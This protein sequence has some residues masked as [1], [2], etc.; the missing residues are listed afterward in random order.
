MYGMIFVATLL[1]VGVGILETSS[2]VAPDWMKKAVESRL[3]HAIGTESI[4]VNE[5]RLGFDLMKLRPE[6]QLQSAEIG[7]T[8]SLESVKVYNLA[9]TVELLPLL[10]NELETHEMSIQEVQARFLY[11]AS[12][13]EPDL[14]EETESATVET[15]GSSE[16]A[17]APVQDPPEMR[18]RLDRLLA[19][20]IEQLAVNSF[21]LEAVDRGTGNHWLVS[22]DDF[23]MAG[24]PGG[25]SGNVSI[26]L[27]RNGQPDPLEFSA[28]AVARQEL[29]GTTVR[30]DISG[31]E[32]ANLSGL[33]SNS[34]VTGTGGESIAASFTLL[35]DEIGKL[36]GAEGST[37]ISQFSLSI[38]GSETPV[39]VQELG[40]FLT[41]DA[42]EN[43]I[44]IQDMLF[45][46]G[47]ASG[48]ASGHAYFVNS[49][50]GGKWPAIAGHL[51]VE[52]ATVAIEALFEDKIENAGAL[53]DFRL[54]LDPPQLEI[55]HLSLF[56]NDLK[57]R[58]RGNFASGPATSIDFEISSLTKDQ[59]LTYWPRTYAAKG[60]NWL[61]NNMRSGQV[62][63]I[64]GSYRRQPGSAPEF[65]MT[66]QFDD[67]SLTYVKQMPP[68]TRGRGFGSLRPKTLDLEFD[69]GR[70]VVPDHGEL[71]ISG[72]RMHIPDTSNGYVP[73]TIHLEV[74]GGMQSILE[75]LDFP[76][77][78]LLEKGRL[79]TESFEGQAKGVATLTLPLIKKLKVA[80]ILVEVEG[81]F[82]DVEAFGDRSGEPFTSG[83]LAVKADNGG[84]E[85][86]G[87]GN[88]GNIPVEGSWS[89]EFGP[90][91]SKG[92]IAKGRT[93]ISGR[94]LDE[95]GL[96]LPK[97]LVTGTESS[98]FF[99]LFAPDSAP[100][101][102]L[103][104]DLEA[105]DLS[106]PF[107]NWRKPPGTAGELL[108]EGQ[109]AE[110]LE[111]RK[112]SISAHG[113]ESNGEIRMTEDGALDRAIFERVALGDR[114]N[115]PVEMYQDEN[116]ELRIDIN[117]G[118][119][120]YRHFAS[121]DA[122]IGGNL[123]FINPIRVN[124]ERVIISPK[125]SLTEFAAE[126]T[127]KGG[128][129]GHFT[130][131]VNGGTA[132]NGAVFRHENGTGLS[133]SSE[134]G[135]A[136]LRAAHISRNVHSGRLRLILVPLPEGQG[137]SGR[138]EVKDARVKDM[139]ALAEILNYSSIVGM[140][141]Q[142][143]G[144]GIHFSNIDADFELSDESVFLKRGTA[145]GSAIG[146]SMKGEFDLERS[147]MDLQGVLTPFY[148]LTEIFTFIVPISDLLGLKAGE[149]LGATNF[150]V[151]GPSDKL[152]VSVN[153]ISS[154]A[155]GFLREQ[156]QPPKP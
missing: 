107:L 71:A 84:I 67:A 100:K 41:Y 91:A 42:E 147:F 40:I 110:S 31:V 51:H 72:S 65:L 24:G 140:I 105:F 34:P 90:E 86:S 89:M 68:I 45:A 154:L 29:P 52:D 77:L 78:N 74:E 43:R 21:S 14:G 87:T 20:G 28:A 148:L 46:S 36:A 128:I 125:I 124:L 150:A 131:K 136:A 16:I 64:T 26:K 138:L 156:F 38:P 39:P 134:S 15:T 155:P 145:V 118:V 114:V 153:P 37:K 44:D 57:V 17:E 8:G 6:V 111:I 99:I 102:I 94:L 48:V 88:L 106:I 98:D 141:E 80:D 92:S 7:R 75:V 130:S 32:L 60:R 143:R 142:L 61:I 19:A 109:L 25:A 18:F 33:F 53:L 135:G 104:S 117:G 63:D 96:S 126:L 101:F 2:I 76:P 144:E 13:A 132:I 59:L 47:L 54:T 73:S 56:A 9:A 122:P 139:P 49:Q 123:N 1:V 69:G 93:E 119:I 81:Q 149:G 70:V 127:A 129:R 79:E 3:M 66:F 12:D 5:I 146:V 30:V 10:N 151:Y 55:A 116:G 23:Q 95:F 133:I 85:V 62:S 115:V 113:L 108:L 50:Q 82:F 97:G 112:F 152:K 22:G 103:S 35:F 11:G 120:D 27:T 58:G 121:S 4:E 137:V 83:G